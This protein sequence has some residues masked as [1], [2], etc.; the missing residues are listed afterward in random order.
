MA[1]LCSKADL[2][3]PNITE[4]SFMLNMPYKE[5]YDEEYIKEILVKLTNLGAKAAAISGVSFDRKEI[6]FY[7]YNSETNE[8]SCYFNERLPV[9]YHGTGDV[10]ASS[11]LAGRMNGLNLHDS[12]SLATDFTLEAI[13][14]TEK[15]QNR[16]FYGVNF[17]EALPF[18]IEKINFLKNP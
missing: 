18:L 4:A 11:T 2:I 15:D 14:Y 12:L 8:F 17:E 1:L 7:L 6:G 13:K 10:F 5:E 16:R 9:S 3:V